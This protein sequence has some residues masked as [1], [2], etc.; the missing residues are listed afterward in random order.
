MPIYF[1]FGL[2]TDVRR[3]MF[4]PI[5]TVSLFVTTFWIS[6]QCRK[7]GGPFCTVASHFYCSY[8]IVSQV[9]IK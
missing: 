4:S 3:K 7:Y 8:A 1:K 6:E 9:R 2:K 5:A